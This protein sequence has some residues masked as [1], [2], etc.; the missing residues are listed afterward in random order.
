MPSETSTNSSSTPHNTSSGFVSAPSTKSNSKLMT[1]TQHQPIKR[2]SSSSP[3]VP[4]SIEVLSIILQDLTKRFKDTNDQLA[5]ETTATDACSPKLNKLLDKNTDLLASRKTLLHQRKLIEGRI[6]S[7]RDDLKSTKTR[8]EKLQRKQGELIEQRDKTQYQLDVLMEQRRE[9][10][11]QLG[12][13][14]YDIALERQFPDKGC[15]EVARRMGWQPLPDPT[16]HQDERST[17]V[18]EEAD[19]NGGDES[20]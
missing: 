5:A 1:A 9:V 19:S 8:A 20:E 6:K 14:R 11:K 7:N 2:E 12:R 4:S 13:K 18:P 17:V 15:R 3:D 10:K 16:Q